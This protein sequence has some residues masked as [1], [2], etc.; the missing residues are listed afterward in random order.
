M[1]RELLENLRDYF[2]NIQEVDDNEEY[3]RGELNKEMGN[4]EVAFLSRS[5]LEK[6][7]YDTSDLTDTDMVELAGMM[8]DYYCD[9]RFTNDLQEACNAL[10]VPVKPHCPMCLG[11]DIAKR[12]DGSNLCRE[13]NQ[14]WGNDYILVQHPQDINY[15]V[16][17]NI[18]YPSLEQEDSQARYVSEYDY[19]DHVGELPTPNSYYRAVPWPQSQQYMGDSSI[20]ALCELINDE[21]GLTDFGPSAMWVP[22]CLLNR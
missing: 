16:N 19:V 12:D 22:L 3:F 5:A 6:H 20:D 15:F 1:R 10:N 4:Y 17:N 9:S 18:G 14:E 21:K 11:I 7:G 8:G 13:C 2:A